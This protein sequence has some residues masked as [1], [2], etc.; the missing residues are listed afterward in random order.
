MERRH[1]LWLPR[2][3]ARMA[4]RDWRGGELRL[5]AAALVI[6]VAAVSSVGFFVDRVHQGMQRDAAQVLGGDAALESDRPI[7]AAWP[8]QAAAWG[9]QDARILSF[10]SMALSGRDADASTLVG[11]K[12]VSAG[13]PLRGVLRIDEG[14]GP[15]AARGIPAPG[16]AW[17][18][19]ELLRSLGLQLGQS[20]RLGH[21]ALRVSALVVAEPDRRLQVLG[22]AP[23]VLLNEA[24]LAASGLVQ[25]ASRVS[26][27]WTVAGTP[28]AVARLVA[29]LRPQL[30]RGQHLETLDEG[31]PDL[32]KNL[33]RAQRFL[34]LVA[35]VTVLI[36]AVAVGSAARRYARR[37][38]DTCALL[39]CFGL[40]QREIAQIF[41]WEFL[42]VGL[43]ASIA[44]VLAGLA[45]HQVLLRELGSFLQGQTPWPS[46]V[47]AAQGIFCGLVLLLGFGLPPVEQLRR[48][49]PLRVL[50]QD[51]GAPAA[52]TVL[53]YLAG[54][55][56]F[57]VLLFWTAGNAR[58]GAIVGGGFLGGV[59]LFAG[60]AR[61][62][63]RALQALRGE[64][65]QRLPVAW[66]YAAAALQRRPAA[67]VAQIVALAMG[68]MALLLLAIVRG[69]LVDQWRGQA[70]PQAPNR[71]FIN[72]Q[73]DQVAAIAARL[74]AA[75]LPEAALEPMV[76]GRLVAVDGRA[77]G[78]ASFEDER[79]RNL[80]E[81]EFNLSYRDDAPAHNRIVQG[82]WLAPGAQELSIEEGIAQRLHIGLG[83]RL[84]FD[85]AGQTV[86][87][88]VSSLRAVD[89]DSM[90][91][92]FF[93]IMNP[94]LLR[95]MP[96]T[97]ITSF[98]LP[99]GEAQLVPGLVRDFP[100]LT[101]ID[102][103]QV[104]GQVRGLLDQLVDAVQFLSAFALAAGVLVL[105]TALAASH[106]ERL[107]ESALLRALGAAR[108]Q[109]AGA[110]AAEMALVG[111]LAGLLA[112][113]G[114]AAIAWAMA[115]YAFDFAFRVPVWLV[116]AGVVAGVGAA[117]LGGWA[118]L[119]RILQAPPLQSLRDA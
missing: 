11:V 38:L 45:L 20:I 64:R 105:Y 44:G 102:T 33:E 113:G 42:Y 14:Q 5:L 16:S 30:G 1:P 85:I 117:L 58:L 119:R 73:P 17:V 106:E 21:V 59:A 99:A 3:A 69:D 53:A 28:D 90:R 43:A 87:A 103:D 100:N 36:A 67:S 77:I 51:V 109:L 57:A 2:L 26:Y 112:A 115:H 40:A 107:R 9:L 80:V 79:T 12:A 76:R 98:R 61:G 74:R 32:Q 22:F 35:L 48:V 68:L 114:A 52:G 84:R 92:N 116:P 31:Q 75:G 71:F 91:V 63:L 49:A 93:V 41:F 89:W 60:V 83:Q 19:A 46:L 4:R 78:P 10:P 72:I 96:Q 55:A 15:R 108:R 56:G 70:P 27:R 29:W 24:D 13:Y 66:R 101:V 50:R 25:P 47:P 34:G 6:A 62:A 18:E 8:R 97:F 95:D 88:T 23:R 81:R 65:W 104:L 86:E 54:A 37:R 39:R 111:L 7:D 118:G 110:Q 94:P 82:H